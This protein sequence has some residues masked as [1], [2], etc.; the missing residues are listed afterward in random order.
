[1]HGGGFGGG[2]SHGGGSHGGHGH[3]SH[4][5]GSH[6]SHGG[7]GGATPSSSVAIFAL[8]DVVR[9]AR[10]LQDE[11]REAKALSQIDAMVAKSSPEDAIKAMSELVKLWREA[12]D[13]AREAAALTALARAYAEDWPQVR[14]A[15]EAYAT[16][17]GLGR[18]LGDR[19][20]EA[21]ALTGL[22][23]IRNRPVPA[24]VEKNARA[25][26]LWHDVGD[27]T[28]EAEALIQLGDAHARG[29]TIEAHP[30][31]LDA[32]RRAADLADK[33]RDQALA[34]RAW[35]GAAD[36]LIS[37]HQFQEAVETYD[38]AVPAEAVEPGHVR[39]ARWAAVNVEPRAREAAG[40]AQAG[41]LARAAETWASIGQAAFSREDGWR[42][43]ARTAA[44]AYT[45]ALELWRELG[46][47]VR[48]AETMTGL[49]VALPHTLGRWPE[50]TETYAEAI[51]A[52]TRAAQL[53]RDLGD[54]T[55][56]ADAL[57]KAGAQQK[58]AKDSLAAARTYAA[59]AALAR[60]LGDR[61]READA[62]M[63][64]GDAHHT[65]PEALAAYSR[66]LVIYRKGLHRAGW[67]RARFDRRRVI[68]EDRFQRGL[69]GSPWEYYS[70]WTVRTARRVIRT[71]PG[72]RRPG[73][74]RP[75]GQ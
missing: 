1:M 59:A 47:P 53:W 35:R 61:V 71:F 6:G 45:R 26:E 15:I 30:Q 46:D 43:P 74:R 34:A 60:D 11:T 66:A 62:L 14:L 55:R 22:G 63:G 21:A 18:E 36:A 33:A 73:R 9:S 8:V 58:E 2:G 65:G 29:L 69:A 38:R 39:W 41:E 67:A 25:A 10:K 49:A 44:D 40:Y 13:Q 16:A 23:G 50:Y 37:L 70:P 57:M 19:A 72:F 31:A 20:L 32:Y 5:G 75:P 28:R 54:R 56:Q 4:G 24:A 64:Q 51:Q 68:C 42:Y 12:G 52:H 7:H 17:A 48:E 27:R 3:G